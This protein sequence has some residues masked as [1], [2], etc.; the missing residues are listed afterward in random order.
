ML[1]HVQT[2]IIDELRDLNPS[3]SEYH[4]GEYYICLYK[5]PLIIIQDTLTSREHQ[6]NDWDKWVSRKDIN[7]PKKVSSDL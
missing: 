1:N 7:F 5:S 2:H 6:R 3:L 4:L